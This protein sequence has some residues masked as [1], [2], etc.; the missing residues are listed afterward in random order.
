MRLPLCILVC[1][2]VAGCTRSNMDS[3]P[4]YHEY[5]QG[6]LFSNGRVLQTPPAGTMARDDAERVEEAKTKP[7]LTA[8]LLARGREQYD[9]FCSPCH[10]RTGSGHGIIVQRGMPQPTSLHDQ[11][12]RSA[13]NQHFYNVISNGYGAMYAHGDRIRPRDRWAIVGYI[14]AL[15]LSQHAA[16]ADLPPDLREGMAAGT[17]P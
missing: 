1:V 15:Q 6:Q 7:A 11:R 16:V 9:I 3:Q 12:L 13:D 17:R 4:K 8:A 14:R 5:E 2:L 10:D